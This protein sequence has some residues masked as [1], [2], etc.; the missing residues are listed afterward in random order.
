VLHELSNYFR[1]QLQDENSE[2]TRAAMAAV[3]RE[4]VIPDDAID[5]DLDGDGVEDVPVGFAG[6]VVEAP[7]V[8]ARLVELPAIVED[9]VA[10]EA[11][12]TDFVASAVNAE[13]VVD[14]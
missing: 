12:A 8:D 11:G 5:A 7:V 2:T 9:P 14:S 10:E 3:P 1:L 13:L 6:T 4:I